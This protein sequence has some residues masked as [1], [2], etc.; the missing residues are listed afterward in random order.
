M[1]CCK[2]EEIKVKGLKLESVLH[3]VGFDKW[4]N[5]KPDRNTFHL[6]KQILKICQ[7]ELSSRLVLWAL[8]Q[9]ENKCFVQ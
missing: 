9:A 7:E 5:K 2:S 4:I 1:P 3:L 6:I 8:D